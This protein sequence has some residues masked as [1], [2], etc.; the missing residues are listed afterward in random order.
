MKAMLIDAPGGP[1]KLV[2]R[3]VPEPS[4]G[5]SRVLVDVKA[6]ALNRADLL[7]R[8]GLYPPPP[9]ASDILGLECAGVVCRLG[10]GVS[11]VKLGDRVMALLPGGGYAERVVIHERMAIPIP[12]SLSFAEAAAIPEAFL[13]ANEALFQRAQLEMGQTVLIHG[14]AGG[15]G[16]AAVQLARG[17]G[18]KVIATASN[19]DKLAKVQELGANILINHKS[20]DFEQV[21]NEAGLTLDV[22]IDSVGAAYWPK[23]ARLLADNGR[24]IVLGLLGGAKVEVDFAT[25]LKKQLQL[26]GIVIRSRELTDKILMTQRFISELLPL[27]EQGQLKPVVDTVFPLARAT[28]AHV[29]MERNENIGKIVLSVSD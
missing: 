16:S 18:A 10:A 27:F 2:L 3:D 14:A 28:D 25:L 17:H 4:V 5:R 12:R 29:R 21:I 9:G 1:E 23:H 20:Q 11:S 22:V 24:L 15:V 26:V 13:T 6:T 19:G 8:R 7:Q